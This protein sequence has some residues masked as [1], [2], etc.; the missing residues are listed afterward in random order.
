[1]TS[2]FLDYLSEFGILYTTILFSAMG[3]CYSCTQNLKFLMHYLHCCKCLA[4]NS[5]MINT[6]NLRT[7]RW[8]VA[9]AIHVLFRLSFILK[10]VWMQCVSQNILNL[11]WKSLIKKILW[12]KLKF[13]TFQFM[14]FKA[15]QFLWSVHI[16]R[17][18]LLSI[19]SDVFSHGRPWFITIFWGKKMLNN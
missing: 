12:K 14:G 11:Q 6:T 4:W 1:M 10:L 9:G 19:K 18:K 16:R 5:T 2:C 15:W 3:L 8:K 17:A 13:K 7:N